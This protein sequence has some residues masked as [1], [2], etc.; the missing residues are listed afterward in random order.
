MKTQGCITLYLGCM[1]AGKTTAIVCML[2]KNFNKKC[3]IIKPLID[4]RYSHTSI[5]S[6]SNLTIKANVCEKLADLDQLVNKF[7]VI[8][9]D[10]GNFFPDIHVYPNKWANNGKKIFIA[11]LNG[12]Y[13]RKPF[14]KI[15]ELIPQCE[16]IKK[17]H[18]ICTYCENKADFSK[19]IIHNNKKIDIGG[20]DKYVAVCRNCQNK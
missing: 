5:Q 19:K 6:H 12:T 14:G 1:F 17:L 13:E 4:T 16:N 8:I 2:Y 20:S 9:I 18:A 10:E 7:D 15:G 3:I 11:A